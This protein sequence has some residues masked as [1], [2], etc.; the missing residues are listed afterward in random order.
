MPITP[1]SLVSAADQGAQNAQAEQMNQY[2]LQQ[3][4]QATHN[5]GLEQQATA[6]MFAPGQPGQ[7]G[8]PPGAAQGQATSMADKL[9][10]KAQFLARNGDT[11]GAMQALNQ[12]A[13]ARKQALDAVHTQV[14][15]SLEHVKLTQAKLG[16]LKTLAD[17][18]HDQQ[19]WQSF[20]QTYSQ[21]M[22]GQ[23]PFAGMPYTP[24]LHDSLNKMYMSTKEQIETTKAKLDQV[25]SGIDIGNAQLRHGLLQDQLNLMPV[26]SQQAQVALQKSQADLEAAKQK[27]ASGAEM[28]TAVPSIAGEAMSRGTFSGV[29]RNAN[30]V[31]KAINH[32]GPTA[33]AHMADVSNQ[34]QSINKSRGILMAKQTVLNASGQT[35]NSNADLLLSIANQNPRDSATPVNAFMQNLAQAKGSEQA[36]QYR[37]A[38][39]ALTNEYA[40]VIANS[41]GAAGASVTALKEAQDAIKSGLTV[42]QLNGVI[43]TMKAEVANQEHAASSELQNLDQR[44]EAVQYAPAAYGAYQPA[45]PK[46]QYPQSGPNSID[47]AFASYRAQGKTPKEITDLLRS[48]GIGVER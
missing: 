5:Q 34:T 25:K 28:D 7:P 4:A 46:Y 41:T 48:Q 10:Q 36:A 40:K 44:Q 18:V 21:M 32:M 22:G 42:G 3:M 17:Q 47:A 31:A 16:T 33:A 6:Q 37:Q 13:A 14:Q 45:N 9:Q 15:T 39:T 23:P 27:A 1:L 11:T 24:D 2:K 26:K 30:L 29:S 19:S 12:A 35:L 38:L 20:Q 43:N 8:Q